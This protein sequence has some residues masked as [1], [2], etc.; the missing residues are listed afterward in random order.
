MSV[1]KLSDQCDIWEF[2]VHG[3]GLIE[4]FGFFVIGVGFI[5]PK[6]KKI[7]KVKKN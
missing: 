1:N 3:R 4:G 5:K 6:I 2:P 7:K